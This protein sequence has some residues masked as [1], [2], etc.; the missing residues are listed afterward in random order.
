MSLPGGLLLPLVW[1]VCGLTIVVCGLLARRHNTAYRLG[2]ATT[3]FL[4]VLAG[5]AVNLEMLLTGRSYSGFADGAQ[6][7][8]VTDTWESLV[9]PHEPVF[10]GLLVA[11]EAVAGVA[12]LVEGRAR[13]LALSALACFN[14]LLVSFGWAFLVWALPLTVALLLLLRATPMT[15][16]HGTSGTPTVPFDPVRP[17]SPTLKM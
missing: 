7:Q 14:V 4:W 13:R 17:R 9:V 10:I 11:G 8:F 16:R 15:A 6:L 5:A 2:I 1:A 3:S 12:V